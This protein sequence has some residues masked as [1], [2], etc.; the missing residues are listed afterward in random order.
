MTFRNIIII[1]KT[2]E[3]PINENH[4]YCGPMNMGDIELFENGLKLSKTPYVLAQIETRL[5]QP[6]KDT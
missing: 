6:Y 5:S 3:I 2:G 1:E 4:L